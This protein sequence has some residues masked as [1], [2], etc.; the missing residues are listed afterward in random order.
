MRVDGVLGGVTVERV[1]SAVGGAVLMQP[2]STE[3]ATTTV[4]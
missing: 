1:G 2:V 3:I 4:R